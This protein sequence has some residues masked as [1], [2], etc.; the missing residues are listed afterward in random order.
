MG[1]LKKNHGF[2][3]TEVLMS[4]GILSVG[5]IFIAGVFPVGIHYTTVATERTK[6]AIVADEAFA[7]IKLYQDKIDFSA[8][9]E[10]VLTDFND[11]LVLGIEFDSK[12]YAYPS[13]YSGESEKYYYWSALCRLKEPYD[14][15]SDPNP[16]VQVTVFVSRRVSPNL[17]YP[18]GQSA[19]PRPVEVDVDAVPNRDA[20]LEI[21]DFSQKRFIND[22]YTIVDDRTGR[23]YR[24]LERYASDDR[25]ILLDQDWDDSAGQPDA[26]WVVPPPINGGRGPCIAVYQ[27]EIQF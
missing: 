26:V 16:V 2:S 25:K 8:L 17:R 3:L 13:V 10:R 18:P 22:G 15:N 21:G 20:E 1:K 23:I 7:K 19:V 27:K 9:D 6:A 14:P 5:M 24:V 11:V 12:E 4:V